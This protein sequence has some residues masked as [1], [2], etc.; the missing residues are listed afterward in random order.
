M[1]KYRESSDYA[2]APPRATYITGQ[3]L[4]RNKWSAG[5][6]ALLA[7]SILEEQVD[8][9]PLC[10]TQVAM[11]CRV[12]LSRVYRA[13]RNGNGHRGNGNG[14]RTTESLADHIARST[15]A[16]RLE[17]ARTVGVDVIWDTLIEP[18]IS[19]EKTAAK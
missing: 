2:S 15:F 7:V 4:A 9:R 16:E 3:F 10:A 14:H 1:F 5:H 12:P 13:R 19:P 18:I 8:P 6:R 17:A 11:L